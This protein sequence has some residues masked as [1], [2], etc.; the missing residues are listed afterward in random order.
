M[1]ERLFFLLVIPADWLSEKFSAREFSKSVGQ[2]LGSYY[3]PGKL[4]VVGFNEI[5]MS[6]DPRKSRAGDASLSKYANP[7]SAR[8]KIGRKVGEILHTEN[9]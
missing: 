7:Y 3:C 6:A 4:E 8:S 5:A 2:P 9:G 1:L